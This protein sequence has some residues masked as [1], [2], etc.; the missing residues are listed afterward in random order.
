[1]S[2][3]TQ[4]SDWNIGA[5]CLLVG[6]VEYCSFSGQTAVWELI[7]WIQKVALMLFLVFLISSSSW[8]IL[9]CRTE[10]TSVTFVCTVCWGDICLCALTLILDDTVHVCVNTNFFLVE[11]VS[12]ASNLVLLPVKGLKELK[13]KESWKEREQTVCRPLADCPV[14]LPHLALGG[15]RWSLCRFAAVWGAAVRPQR[16]VGLVR[17]PHWRV[18]QVSGVFGVLVGQLLLNES[19]K[20]DDQLV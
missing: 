9:T 6:I 12:Q 17:L 16:G 11:L 7:G 4:L 19:L 3:S 2:T 8:E 15:W 10:T 20:R 1:M 5:V 13:Q 14:L 18:T